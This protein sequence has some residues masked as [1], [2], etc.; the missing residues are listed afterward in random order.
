MIAVRRSSALVALA[1][2]SVF[3]AACSTSDPTAGGVD[4]TTVPGTG[5]TSSTAPTPSTPTAAT[6][7]PVPS[8]T[9]SPSVVPGYC[10]MDEPVDQVLV[11]D[12]AAFDSADR[13]SVHFTPCTLD[14]STPNAIIYLLHGAGADE[15]QWPDVGI[16]AAADAAVLDGTLPPTILVAPDAADFTCKGCSADLLSHLVDE[17]EPAV[18][19]MAPVDPNRRAIGGISR[20]GALALQVAAVAPGDFVALGAHSPANAPEPALIAIADARLPVRFDAGADD[21]LARASER[22]AALIDDHGGHAQIEVGPG[23]HDRDYWRSQA[24]TYIAFYAPY[25]R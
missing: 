21:S 25:L 22:M 23:R 6:T 1:A 24:S 11:V 19:H 17:I 4:P 10:S 7:A 20:G 5:A 2:A 8:P 9:G 16:F 3:L 18:E 12:S 15:T 14:Q 13:V